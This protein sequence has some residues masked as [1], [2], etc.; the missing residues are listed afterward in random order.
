MCGLCFVL[1]KRTDGNMSIIILRLHPTRGSP[2]D[3]RLVANTWCNCSTRSDM[4]SEFGVW[5]RERPSGKKRQ[6]FVSIRTRGSQEWPFGRQIYVCKNTDPRVRSAG[7]T[8]GSAEN[9]S[10][11]IVIRPASDPYLTGQNPTRP[12]TFS[13][14]HEATRPDP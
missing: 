1:S 9:N 2:N 11:V 4:R 8:R 10:R 5:P 14:P 6:V 7:P 3:V 12:A 13:T